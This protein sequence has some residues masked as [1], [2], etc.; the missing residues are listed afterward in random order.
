MREVRI[1]SLEKLEVTEDEV[2][3]LVNSDLTLVFPHSLWENAISEASSPSS[4]DP[5]ELEELHNL[6]VRLKEHAGQNSFTTVLEDVPLS[7][8]L[9]DE[10]PEWQF[11]LVLR[12]AGMFAMTTGY[13]FLPAVT[14]KHVSRFG[15]K[16]EED[17]FVEQAYLVGAVAETRSLAAGDERLKVLSIRERRC[18]SSRFELAPELWQVLSEKLGWSNVEPVAPIRGA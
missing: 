13:L 16:L 11:D 5:R 18:S 7:G 12:S 6:K 3:I 2:R 4:P 9:G 14:P 10:D 1:E 17:D 15:A 8:S